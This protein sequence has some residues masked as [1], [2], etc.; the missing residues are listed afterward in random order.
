[1]IKFSII[2]TSEASI[3]HIKGIKKSDQA[4][5]KYI[6]SRNI[7]RANEF[8]KRFKLIPTDNF[9]L[10][11]DDK[12]VDALII[13]TEPSRHATLAVKAL[14]FDKHVLIE[15]PVDSD[16]DNAKKLLDNVKSK[17]SKLV[18]SVVSQNRFDPII[19]EMKKQL[20]LGSIGEPFLCEVKMFWNRNS[21]YYSRGNGWRGN[22]GNVLLNQGVHFLDLVI[23]FFG[24]PEK[25]DSRLY[26]VNSD[27]NCFDSAIVTLRFP[28]NMYASMIFSTACRYSEPFEF[29]IYGQKGNLNYRKRTGLSNRLPIKAH[30][31][32]EM[33]KKIYWTYKSPLLLQLEDFINS[34][35]YNKPPAVSI[36]EAYE[37]LNV[38]KEC[39]NNFVD[40]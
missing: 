1:V 8:S 29:N 21:E 4:D 15:K 32:S 38:V 23:W 22:I 24:Y 7:N 25:I 19:T 39:E 26:Q 9:N 35:N 5:C 30:L 17:K 31:I 12:N 36:R 11:L 28:H 20:E 33:I 14:D 10:I 13:T 34:I 27:I 18:A 3:S 16:L 37:V 2:G 40:F 6:Y